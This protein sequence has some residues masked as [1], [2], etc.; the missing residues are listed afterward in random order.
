MLAYKKDYGQIIVWDSPL[1]NYDNFPFRIP[2]EIAY[3]KVKTR[4][5]D[6]Y[7]EP[8]LCSP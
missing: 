1:M 5:S 8:H 6:A 4:S 2:E 3:G 7:I